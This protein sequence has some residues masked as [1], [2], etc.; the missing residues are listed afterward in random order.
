MPKNMIPTLYDYWVQ[1]VELLK[2]KEI[3]RLDY[4]FD[5]F[6]QRE[7]V[8]STTDYVKEIERYNSFV[9]EEAEDA[10]HRFIE[11]VQA[12]YAEFE[13]LYGKAQKDTKRKQNIDILQFLMDNSD[14]LNREEN[15]WML[16][17]MEAVR[18][19]SLYFQPQ[20]RTKILNEGW[21]S[22]WHE[23]LFLRDDRING[24][25]SDFARVNAKVTAMPRVG[26]NP[27]ALDMRLFSYI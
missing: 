16:M 5:V 26:L 18:G 9:R 11:T 6:L 14:F 20:I 27:Y 22:Y 2:G 25:E 1:D 19:T 12:K 21:A 13:S 7:N 10:E 4:Y 23:E 17:I 3:S 15:T 24:H 8:V